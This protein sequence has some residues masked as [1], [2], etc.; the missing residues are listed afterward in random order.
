MGRNV[1]ISAEIS[2]ETKDLLDSFSRSTG[3]KKARL[4]EDA[5]HQYITA[6]EALPPE[7]IVHSRVIISRDS[8]ERLARRLESEPS[9]TPALRELMNPRAD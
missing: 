6:L 2:P 9:P 1:Q 4:V 7:V 8:A 5:V 3:I